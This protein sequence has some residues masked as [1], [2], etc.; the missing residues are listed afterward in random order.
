MWFQKE[1]ETPTLPVS[2]DAVWE[3]LQSLTL[4]EKNRCAI[5]AI[6]DQLS[7]ARRNWTVSVIVLGVGLLAATGVSGWSLY[8]L[9]QIQQQT[10]T[11]QSEASSN[12]N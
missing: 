12:G 5:E 9:N 2:A 6:E 10:L 1:P 7:R 11:H 8:Q 4:L 3:T